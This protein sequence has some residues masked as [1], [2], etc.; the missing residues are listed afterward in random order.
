M[1]TADKDPNKTELFKK[2]IKRL[3]DLFQAYS[4]RRFISGTGLSRL[5]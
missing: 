5:T 2:R 1:D 3:V 4:E